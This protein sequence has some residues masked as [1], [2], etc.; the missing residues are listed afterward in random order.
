MNNDTHTIEIDRLVLTGVD[1]RNL[2]RL[3]ARIQAEVQ[4]ALGGT[5]LSASPQIADARGG[6]ATETAAAVVN[7]IRG[8]RG[9]I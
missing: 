1:L 5:Q 7:A 3:R 2:P 6:L 8:G 9:G 4:R